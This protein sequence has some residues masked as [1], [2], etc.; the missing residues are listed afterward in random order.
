MTPPTCFYIGAIFSL[1]LV[2]HVL[3]SQH[4]DQPPVAKSWTKDRL[5]YLA[6]QV[7]KDWAVEQTGGGS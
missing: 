7:M 1:W 4:L 3:L 5:W 6:P 2:K